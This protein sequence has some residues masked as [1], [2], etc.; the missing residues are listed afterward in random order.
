MPQ[1]ISDSGPL[2]LSRNFKGP[3]GR[4]QTSVKYQST[5]NV[6]E[7]IIDAYPQACESQEK[8]TLKLPLHVAMDNNNTSLVPILWA[9]YP[10]AINATD[11]YGQ[12]PIP[13]SVNP[14]LKPHFKTHD[15]KSGFKTL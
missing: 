6:V 7:R 2:I 12:T 14:K 13:T 8:D 11:I 3:A 9:T 4:V 15:V 5:E 1:K 10:A